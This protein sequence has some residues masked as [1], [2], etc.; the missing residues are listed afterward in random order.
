MKWN[1]EQMICHLHRR[2]KFCDGKCVGVKRHQGS[3]KTCFTGIQLFPE[4]NTFICFEVTI[5]VESG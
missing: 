4:G 1:S 5:N 3:S 2:L